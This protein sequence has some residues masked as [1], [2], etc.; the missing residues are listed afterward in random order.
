MVGGVVDGDVGGDVLGLAGELGGELG[1]V[2]VEV[3]GAGD[4]RRELADGL[5][6]ADV[7]GTDWLWKLGCGEAL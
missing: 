2:S 6:A 5:G 4:G 1:V 7:A 3:V